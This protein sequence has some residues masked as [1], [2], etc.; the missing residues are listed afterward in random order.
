MPYVRREVQCGRVKEVRKMFTGRIHTKGARRSAQ[1]GTTSEMQKAINERRA[2]DELRWILNT[3][4]QRGDFHVVLHYYDKEVTLEQSEK[5]LTKFLRLLRNRKK[6]RG[7]SFRFVACTETKRMTNVHHHIIMEKSDLQELQDLWDKT[8][9]PNGNVSLKPMD[10][11]GQHAKLAHYLMKETRKTMERFREMGRKVNRFRKS[12]NLRRPK[13]H[14]EIVKAD[15]W[16]ETPKARKG[17]YLYKFDHGETTRTGIDRNGWPWQEYFEI[18][19]E[20]DGSPKKP[21]RK[22]KQHGKGNDSVRRVRGDSGP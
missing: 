4:F 10:S 18:Y 1:T 11:R 8:I 15:Y 16:T 12:R 20:P 9:G 5:D 3:N 13:I 6:A 2:E 17:S 22:E 14:Y 21:K 7:E 19:E